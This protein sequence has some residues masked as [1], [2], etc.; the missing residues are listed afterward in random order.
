MIH[1]ESKEKKMKTNLKKNTKNIKKKGKHAS[2][3]VLNIYCKKMK[4]DNNSINE[5]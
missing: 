3:Y 2:L 5:E 1:Q 4:E